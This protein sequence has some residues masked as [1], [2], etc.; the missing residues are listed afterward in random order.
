LA[1]KTIFAT[2]VFFSTDKPFFPPTSKNLPTLHL[3]CLD[4]LGFLKPSEIAGARFILDD[5]MR[6]VWT[7]DWHIETASIPII[8]QM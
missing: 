8:Y 3:T 5:N 6:R 2:T 7:T 4:G 1:A